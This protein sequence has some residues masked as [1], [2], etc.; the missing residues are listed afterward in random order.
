MSHH[1][2]GHQNTQDHE[3]ENIEVWEDLVHIKDL[4]LA[5]LICSVTTLSGYFIAPS[6]PPKPLFFGLFGALIGFLITSI[7]IQPKRTF[8]GTKEEK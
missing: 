2:K 4:L 7:I 6:E 8:N 1:K 5:L 3:K